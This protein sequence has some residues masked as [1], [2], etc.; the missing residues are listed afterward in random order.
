MNLVAFRADWPLG[1]PA[2]VPESEDVQHC[3]FLFFEWAF[4]ADFYS[5]TSYI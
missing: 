3:F 5:L 4:E 2:F 1:N